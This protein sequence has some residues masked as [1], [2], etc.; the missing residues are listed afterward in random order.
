MS[1]FMSTQPF[2]VL[3]SFQGS[4]RPSAHNNPDAY[5]LH[6]GLPNEAFCI[7]M[8]EGQWEVYYSERGNKSML[9]IFQNEEQACQY[10]Y[11]WMLRVFNK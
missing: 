6:G 3:V 8:I 9:K 5:S 7:G 11:E 1:E 2:F 10:F 4:A